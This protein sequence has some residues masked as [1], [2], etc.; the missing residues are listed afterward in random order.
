[1]LFLLRSE[2]V[3][4]QDGEFSS[5][6]IILSSDFPIK[7]VAGRVTKELADVV[8]EVVAAAT[9]GVVVIILVDEIGESVAGGGGVGGGSKFSTAEVGLD[10]DVSPYS[11]GMGDLRS[12]IG[13][14]FE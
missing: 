12:D 11:E 9:D 3:R 7:L 5:G 1:M 14:I 4:R 13:T 8:G 2:L 6:T 10:F